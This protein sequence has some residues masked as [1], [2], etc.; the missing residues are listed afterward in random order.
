LTVVYGFRYDIYTPFTEAHNHISNFD[1]Y[2]ALAATSATAAQAALQVASVNGVS[3]TA[4][5][6]TDHADFAPRIGF[7]FAPLPNLVVRGGYGISYFPGNYTSNADL[8]NAPFTSV[9]SPSCESIAAYNIQVNAGSAP[10]SVKS[11]CSGSGYQ[12][13]FDSGLPTPSPQTITSA[14]LSF[15][16]EDPSIRSSMI[17][18]FNLQVERQF[19][20]NVLTIGYVGNIG[21]HLPEPLSDINDPTPAQVKVGGYNTPRPLNTFL[22]NVG[23][24]NWLLTGG[25]SNYNGLQMSFQRRFVKGLAFDG[26]YTYSHALSDVVGFSEEGHQ[27]WGDADPTNIRKYEY[28]NAENDIRHRFALSINYEL[29]LKNFTSRVERIA[30]GGWQINS[31]VAWQSGK[32]F[33]VVNGTGETVTGSSASYSNWAT[34]QYNGG[35]DRPNQIGDPFKPGNFAANPGCVGP[36]KIKAIG[37][38]GSE[39]DWFNPCAFVPQAMGTVGNTARNS[40]YGPH[41]R[42]IDFSLFKDFEL[43]EGVKLQF[44]AEAF[45]LTNTPSFYL[46]NNI[47]STEGVMSN[48][49]GNKFAQVV[50]TDPNYVPRQLQ[51]ALK[52]EF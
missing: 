24:V 28:G 40:I 26:N 18:Q 10:S 30:L 1:Y 15:V 16:A 22:S 9:Y 41:F 44:R 37:Q 7:S 52:L 46:N 39:S 23:G 5:I 6:K 12:S 13:I 8:K 17:Q 4:G 47:H 34:P 36:T 29:P 35:P 38:P 20:P 48:S 32:P 21:Q 42:H 33:S 14:A 19:G 2:S 11:A 3:A 31:I 50:A 25:V 43:V 45:N 49:T 27:G 51:L